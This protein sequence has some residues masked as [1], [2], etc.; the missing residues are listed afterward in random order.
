MDPQ[1]YSFG[2]SLRMLSAMVVAV[3]ILPGDTLL[4]TTSPLPSQSSAQAPKIS[5]DHL[6]SLVAPIALYQDPLLAQTLAASTYP[7]ELIQLQQ[8]L[9]KNPGLKD[10]AL[11]DAVAK[12]PWDPSIQALAGLPDVV[13]RLADDIQWTTDLGNACL[14]Q[15]GD[16]M[17]AAQR[18]RKKAQNNGNLKSGEQQRVETK[19]I[20]NKSVIVIEQSHPQVVYV[21]SYDPLVA[22]GAPLFTSPPIY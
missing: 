8:W 17:D 20:E 12:Q 10:Q 13:K 11:A 3:A 18:M 14:A 15:Q 22:W 9:L 6:D 7:L 21:T 1:P 19:V 5:P 4:S 16:L 2:K